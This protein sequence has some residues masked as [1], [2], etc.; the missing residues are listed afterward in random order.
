MSEILLL[1][2]TGFVSKACAKYLISR[3]YDIDIL[4]RGKNKVDYDGFINHI[5]CDRQNL[6]EM[7]K[8][9]SDKNY[10]YI[11]DFSGYK[12]KDIEIL[13][14]SINNIDSLKRYVFCSSGAVYAL[15]DNHLTESS[16]IEPDN[17]WGNYAIDKLE[18]ENYIFDL[19]KNKNLHATIFRPSYIYGAGN[20]LYRESYFF[21]RI[22]NNKVITIP[23]SDV[24][25]QFINIIDVVKN[26]ECA[27][28]NDNDCRA[29]NLSTRE[30]VTFE[31]FIKACG[32]T[33]GKDPI[34]K[35]VPLGDIDV[36]RD[37]PFRNI[38]YCL[39]I[40]NLRENGLHSPMYNLEQGLELTYKW[41]KS[42]KPELKDSRMDLVDSI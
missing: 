9:L 37:F 16:K 23:D 3:G 42:E 1:G 14:K 28:Y 17:I 10:S 26:F 11:L 32:K 13:F 35:K 20:N 40:T 5:I 21:D 2:G 41:Y 36:R 8:N 12:K 29:Y 38:N 31:D 6:D 19:I 27:M 7:K 24:K 22:L 30:D 25:V 33:V 15:N 39:D 4:T 34:I 18:C